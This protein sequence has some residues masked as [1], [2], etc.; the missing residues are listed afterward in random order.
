MMSLTLIPA[1]EGTPV[2]QHT[3]D[4]QSLGGGF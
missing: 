4:A 2:Q 3:G 1:C